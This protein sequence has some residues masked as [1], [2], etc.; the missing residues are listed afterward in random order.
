MYCKIY[1]KMWFMYKANQLTKSK[2]ILFKLF[3]K[4]YFQL[5]DE[6]GKELEELRK[7]KID[8]ELNQSPRPR[9]NSMADLPG[10]YQALNSEV[11]RLKEVSICRVN[12]DQLYKVFWNVETEYHFDLLFYQRKVHWTVVEVIYLISDFIVYIQWY[13]SSL[14][15]VW[16]CIWYRFKFFFSNLR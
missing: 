16:E 13:L 6:L 14:A 11:N 12:T 5:L 8:H 2:V 3:S 1:L 15:F 4:I 10:R 9:N 7:Y